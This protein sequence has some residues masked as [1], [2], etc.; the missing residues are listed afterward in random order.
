MHKLALQSFGSGT[1]SGDESSLFDNI[2]DDILE[3]GYS[4]QHN[5]L[6][7]ALASLLWEHLQAMPT[8]KFRDA[9]IG[10][11]RDQAVNKFVRTDEICWIT[12]N[13]VAGSTWIDW[14]ASLQQHLNR[15]LLL[16]LFSF[17][18]HFSHYGEGDFYKTHRDA[19]KGESNRVLSLVTYLNPNWQFG[20]GGELVI[21]T[22]DNGASS[23]RVNPIFGTLVLFLSEDFPHEVLVSKNDRYSIAGWFRLNTS[24]TE[25]V[26]PPV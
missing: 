18:S 1:G 17:E 15:R 7:P 25:R 23:V 6:P 24:S 13:S 20:D 14:S 21:Y 19:F 12:G 4:V 22:D 3:K 8:Y 10:R 5:A 11:E 9:G 16:G 2:S 26:D